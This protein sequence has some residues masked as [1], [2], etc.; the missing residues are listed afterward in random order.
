MFNFAI[1]IILINRLK[2][3]SIFNIKSITF[4]SFFPT[5]PKMRNVRKT[6]QKQQKPKGSSIDSQSLDRHTRDPS[7]RSG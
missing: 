4:N 6:Q 7:L 1:Y 5:L 2:K 3:V